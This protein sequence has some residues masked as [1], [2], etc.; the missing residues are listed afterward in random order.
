[1]PKS[2]RTFEI[3]II[4]LVAFGGLAKNTVLAWDFFKTDHV[5]TAFLESLEGGETRKYLKNYFFKIIFGF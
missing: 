5:G 1:M 2:C 4:R 3:L